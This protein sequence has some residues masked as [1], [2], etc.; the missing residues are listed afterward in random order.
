MIIFVGESI[1]MAFGAVRELFECNPSLK[2][3]LLNL[4]RLVIVASIAGIVCVGVCM[5]GRTGYVA[6]TAVIYWKAV[7]HQP[8]WSPRLFRV[9]IH[10]LQTEETSVDFGLCV[11][12]RTFPGS[13]FERSILMA[14]RAG[15]RLVGAVQ[16]EYLV[17][18]EIAHAVDPVVAIHALRS[19]LGSVLLHEFC[20]ARILLQVTRPCMAGDTGLNVNFVDIRCMTAFAGDRIAVVILGMEDQAES[21]IRRMIERL[22]IQIG[23]QPGICAVAEGTICGKYTQM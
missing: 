6:I 16:W 12:G 5:A 20:F 19:I 3:C 22:P 2:V 14:I 15:N 11:A 13:A 10:A 18:V 4:L 1:K 17:M 21:G 8:G 7:F 9:A 23:G